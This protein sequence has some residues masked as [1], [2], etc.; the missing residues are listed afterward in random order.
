[1]ASFDP[2]GPVALQLK[3]A[4]TSELQNKFG[5]HDDAED[6]AEFIL[7]LIGNNRTASDIVAEVRGLI[8]IAI[9]E[10][11]IEGVFEEIRRLQQPQQQQQHPQQ[12]QQQQQ[13]PQQQQQQQPLQPP[14]QPPPYQEAPAQPYTL[15][16]A[17]PSG[18]ALAASPAA[19]AP[20]FHPILSFPQGPKGAPRGAPGAGAS[21]ASRIGKRPTGPKK[22][23]ALQSS[24]NLD[25]VLALNGG[26]LAGNVKKA[27]KRETRGRCADFPYCTNRDCP[28]LHPTKVC[29][30]YPNC[31]NPPGTCNYLHPDQDQEL[32]AK[33]EQLK[34][35]FYE[36]KKVERAQ[37]QL[38]QQQQWAPL[39][40][41]CKFGQRCAKAG[42]AFGHPTPANRNAIVGQ[43]EWC[44]Q[45]NGCTENSCVKAHPSPASGEGAVG[46]EVP[47]QEAGPQAA[48]GRTLEQCKFGAS[49]TNYKCPR[50]HATTPVPCRE[51][52][53][54]TRPDCFFL[55]PIDEDCRFGANCTNK[56]CMFRHP[57]GKALPLNTWTKDTQERQFAVPD[58]QVMEQ[59]TQS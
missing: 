55:H 54:C 6:V 52:A 58:D 34:R 27:G 25:K 33:L 56:T 43:L 42:C 57:E 44:P 3:P 20:T 51:G 11:F 31:P 5:I 12:Q 16:F 23:F 13:Q 29:F 35:E 30:A 36:K 7:V 37:Q 53:Q 39:I 26:E 14:L 28:F 48:P 17:Q 2:E 32:M 40:T 41:L 50:R 46:G 19:A 59:A 24:A 22:S 1:M 21:L 8:E 10:Q 18:G 4:L 45:G 47:M 38:Q 9:D 49:C 15:P